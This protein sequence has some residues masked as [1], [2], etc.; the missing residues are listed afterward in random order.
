VVLTQVDPDALG[1]GFGFAYFVKKQLGLSVLPRIV[2]CGSIGHPQNRSI[3]N[4]FNLKQWMVPLAEYSFGSAEVLA[5]IDSSSIQDSR[6][7]IPE[8]LEV[9]VIIDHHRG[10]ELAPSPERCIWIEEVGAASTLVTELFSSSGMAMDEDWAFIQTLLTLGIYTDTKSLAGAGQRDKDAFGF[11]AKNVAPEELVQLLN[12]PLPPSYFEHLKQAL[13]A[14]RREGSVIVTTPG[15][16]AAS[17]S[18]DLSTIADELLRTDGVT[19]VVVYGILEN[20]KVRISARSRGL[21]TALD[22]Y[23]KFRFGPGTGAKFT[24]DG[25]GEGGGLLDLNLGF[26][27]GDSNRATVLQMVE[28]RM[29]EVIFVS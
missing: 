9:K 19:L 4:K 26:W 17:S 6:F 27:K 2:Y 15:Y 7:K 3:I 1:G 16:I 23:L 21:T 29:A 8:G 14:M 5:L 13:V 18:D 12:Y 24:P 25:R 22:E 28:E 20:G 11:M 10:G